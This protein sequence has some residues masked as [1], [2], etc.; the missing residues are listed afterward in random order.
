MTHSSSKSSVDINQVVKVL[1]KVMYM[2][3]KIGRKLGFDYIVKISSLEEFQVI[4][5]LTLARSA[6]MC[7]LYAYHGLPY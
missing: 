5:I 3:V 6:A 7:L 4:L 1:F 2:V